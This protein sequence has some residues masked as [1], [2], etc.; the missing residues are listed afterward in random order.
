VP[1]YI[2]CNYSTDICITYCTIQL[3]IYTYSLLWAIISLY[4]LSAVNSRNT[5]IYHI[6]KWKSDKLHS[7]EYTSSTPTVQTW[8][9]ELKMKQRTGQSTRQSS[10]TPS[11]IAAGCYLYLASARLSTENLRSPL[12]QVTP[13]LTKKASALCADE[14]YPERD[15]DEVEKNT[16]QEVN[17]N[18]SHGNN[19]SKPEATT[20][21]EIA[22]MQ[23]MIKTQQ[24]LLHRSIELNP[25]RWAENAEQME[26]NWEH[27]SMSIQPEA[28]K[29]KISNMT[30]P[31][32]YCGRAKEFDDFLHTLQSNFES[33]CALIP[34][35]RCWQCL[36]C[37]KPSQHMDRLSRPGT[38]TYTDDWP[39]RMASR[40]TERLRYQFRQHWA[41]VSWNADGLQQ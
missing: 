24:L 9:N 30:H 19:P 6:F 26:A 25:L 34:A 12:G 38:E 31:E 28:M 41:L 13:S 17:L 7:W 14:I 37:S 18:A 33:W 20:Q 27:C 4:N 21:S 10:T 15:Q 16:K 8:Q 39:Y 1:V 23:K 32:W 11:K 2:H 5:F 22:S 40:S 35:C 36:V 29:M 3:Y